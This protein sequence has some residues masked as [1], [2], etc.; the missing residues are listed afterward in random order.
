MTAPLTP[1]DKRKITLQQRLGE[2]WRKKIGQSAK[3]AKIEKHGADGYLKV[4]GLA[5]K[6]GGAKVSAAKRP[7]TK[8]KE[9][10]RS[11]GKKGGENRWKNEGKK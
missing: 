7:F 11:A 5:G 4:Q 1:A 6:K 10:A 9:L 3:G 2:D 8:N